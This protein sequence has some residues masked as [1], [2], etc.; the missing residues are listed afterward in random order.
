MQ[1]DIDQILNKHWILL[2]SASTGTGGTRSN[3]R[4]QRG[5]N[6]QS[7]TATAE[8]TNKFKGKVDTLATLGTR[9]EKK[10]DSFLIFQKDLYEY[11]LANYKHP[12]DIAYLVKELKDPVKRLMSEIHTVAKLESEWG[13]AEDESKYSID[14]QQTL[15]DLQELLAPERKAFVDR[16]SVLTQNFSKLYGLV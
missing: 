14:D 12:S 4:N 10:G 3:R 2:D 7:G 13:L 5:K 16:K 9:D 15:A 1:N 11:V 8:A 6:G